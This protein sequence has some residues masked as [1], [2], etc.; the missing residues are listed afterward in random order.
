MNALRRPTKARAL[1]QVYQLHVQLEDIKP[2]IWRRLWVPGNLPLAKLDRVIQAAM[3]WQNMHLHAFD[4][5]QVRY[6]LPDPEW[7]QEEDRDER[8]YDLD[9]VLADGTTEFVYTYDYGDDWRHHVRVE[10]ILTPDEKNRR[11]TCI[12][13]ANACPPED[14]GGPPGYG[15]FLHAMSDSLHPQQMAMWGWY[16]GPFDPKAFDMNAVNAALRKLRL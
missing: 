3:G 8:K 9:S 1:Q 10:E 4:I 5:A 14:V 16:G 12:A 11:T 7:P 2:V 6:A 13:G 15:E